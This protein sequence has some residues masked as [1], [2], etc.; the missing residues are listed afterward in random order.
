[1]GLVYSHLDNKGEE[2]RAAIRERAGELRR[3]AREG[4]L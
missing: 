3:R 2:E 1:M 4:D